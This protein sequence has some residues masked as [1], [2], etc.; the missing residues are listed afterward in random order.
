M[1]HYKP[2]NWGYPPNH[3]TPHISPLTMSGIHQVA[4]PYSY[5]DPVNMEVYGGF[6][7][8]GG[9]PVV[10]IGFNAKSAKKNGPDD[11][12]QG[13]TPWLTDT[14]AKGYQRLTQG[15][16]ESC[17]GSRSLKPWRWGH[18]QE[19]EPI[20]DPG[21]QVGQKHVCFFVAMTQYKVAPQFVS[22]GR[23]RPTVGLKVVILY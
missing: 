17:T 11:W 20:G 19:A 13:G 1:L 12:M 4:S 9:S 22:E 6:P 14:S 8:I 3:G 21:P 16:A 2:S 5:S 10:T 15:A 7:K 23:T 18:F